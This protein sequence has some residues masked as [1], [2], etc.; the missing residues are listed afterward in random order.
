LA[1][2]FGV[3]L[4]GTGTGYNT[5]IDACGLRVV[6]DRRVKLTGG[7]ATDDAGSNPTGDDDFDGMLASLPHLKLLS[8]QRTRPAGRRDEV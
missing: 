1:I 6:V 5:G 8:G 3:N 7:R 2:N 4:V